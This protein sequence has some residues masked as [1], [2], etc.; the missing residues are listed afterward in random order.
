MIIPSLPTDSLYK[1]G[2]VGGLFMVFL[3]YYS[4]ILKVENYND[5]SYKLDI[6]QVKL[7]IEMRSLRESFDMLAPMFNNIQDAQQEAYVLSKSEELEKRHD[8]LRTR[9]MELKV[10]T[11]FF[12]HESRRIIDFKILTFVLIF[13]GL[14]VSIV[15][16]WLWYNKIQKFQ[17]YILERKYK[18]L[19][20]GE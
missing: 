13:S 9:E 14:G 20:S 2:F 12:D 18:D 7:E 4:L 1:F 17:D 10:Q 6:E 11:D 8:L 5:L 16:G 15:S 19:K 3:S